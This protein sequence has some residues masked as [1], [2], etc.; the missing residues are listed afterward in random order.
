MATD[1]DVIIGLAYY[2]PEHLTLAGDEKQLRLV[3][4]FRNR[5][6][7]FTCQLSKSCSNDY[8]NL[9]TLHLGFSNNLG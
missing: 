9:D 1:L 2:I 5:S 8:T 7:C 4:M 3:P 6:N